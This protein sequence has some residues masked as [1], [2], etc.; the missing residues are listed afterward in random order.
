MDA[1]ALEVVDSYRL[2]NK[3]KTL[4]KSGRPTTFLKVAEELGLGVADRNKIQLD[5]IELPPFVA[6]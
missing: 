3:L 6:G 4:E 5:N 2:Q 1:I